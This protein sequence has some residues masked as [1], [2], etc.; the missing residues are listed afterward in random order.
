MTSVYEF[1]P[2]GSQPDDEVSRFYWL[3]EPDTAEPITSYSAETGPLEHGDPIAFQAVRIDCWPAQ[4]N[5][6]YI[7]ATTVTPV[8]K[9]GGPIEGGLSVHSAQEHL[10]HAEVLD[11][12]GYVLIDEAAPIPVDPTL[13][14]ID[15]VDAADD[16]PAEGP[17]PLACFGVRSTAELW[18]WVPGDGGAL[19]WQQ[20]PWDDGV[21]AF[22][23]ESLDGA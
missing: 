20:R 16:V 18:G 2:P 8:D 15:I 9:A 10:T 12:L 13:H 1:T 21:T 3:A 14:L 22:F 17:D 5:V 6:T 19:G 23:G 4:E 11:R 7:P